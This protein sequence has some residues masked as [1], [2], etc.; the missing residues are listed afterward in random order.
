V[1]KGSLVARIAGA[2]AADVDADAAAAAAARAG[3]SAD[4]N[5]REERR[6]SERAS[7]AAGEFA[8]LYRLP[9]DAAEQLRGMIE[10][11]LARDPA[12]TTAPAP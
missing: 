5:A 10:A 7:R 9:A 3:A 4:G 11:A 6:R 8:R 1:R 12:A 2:P